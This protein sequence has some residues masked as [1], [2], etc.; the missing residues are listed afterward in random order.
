[1]KQGQTD[2]FICVYLG[3]T[4]CER[5]YPECLQVKEFA[6]ARQG[7]N[8][9]DACIYRTRITPNDYLQV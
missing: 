1:M 6:Y 8:M 9:Q 3:G 2:Q 7:K 4:A 5:D